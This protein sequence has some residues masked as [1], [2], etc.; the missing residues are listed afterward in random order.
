MT[1]NVFGVMLNPAQSNPI[2]MVTVADCTC[3]MTM[4]TAPAWADV[5]SVGLYT[6]VGLLKQDS[7]IIE[8]IH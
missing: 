1:Y 3:K 7:S 8:I 4:Q 6:G 2:D 5:R